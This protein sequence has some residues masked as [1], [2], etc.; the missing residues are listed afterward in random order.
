MIEL[1]GIYD[2]NMVSILLNMLLGYSLLS[3]EIDKI[4]C[5]FLAI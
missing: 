3:G 2:F 4:S 5:K 1:S